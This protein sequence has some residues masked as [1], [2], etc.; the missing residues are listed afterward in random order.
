MKNYSKQIDS[1]LLNKLSPIDK[2]EFEKELTKNQSLRKKLDICKDLHDSVQEDDIFTLREKL[3]RAES[4]IGRKKNKPFKIVSYLT[5]ASIAIV[6][7]LRF[8]VFSPSP[9]YDEL[10]EKYFEPFEI[11]GDTRSVESINDA[12]LSDDIIKKYFNGKYFDII[13]EIESIAIDNP[14]KT[15]ISL[16]LAT[17]YLETNQE[18]KA[19]NLLSNI[20]VEN[21]NGLYIEQ[22]KWYLSLSI[23]KQGKTDEAKNLLTKIEKEEGFYSKRA[24]S[25]LKSL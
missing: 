17:A 8:F 23:I 7:T 25:I 13:S 18:D 21:K 4:D 15:E 11:I 9:S 16:M 20:L 5:A 3:K 24:T 2:E 22:I 14:S 19:E 10:F 1:Y 6:I 12:L